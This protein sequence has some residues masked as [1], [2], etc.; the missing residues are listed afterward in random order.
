MIYTNANDLYI[1]MTRRLLEEGIRSSPRGMPVRE[2]LNVQLQITNP[3]WSVVG[4]SGRALNYHFM[5]GESLWMLSGLNR[6]DLI[7][8]FNRNIV[9]ALDDGMHWFQGAY[10][11]KII[12][13]L[14]YVIEVLRQDRA[15]RQA[16][17]TIW[18]ERPR[19]SKDIPC[20]IMMQF[21]IRKDQ[22]HMHTYMRSND[23][24]LGVP[25]DLYNFMLLQQLVAYEMNADLGTY[26]HTVGSIHLYERDEDAARAM[27]KD[28]DAHRVD[29]PMKRVRSAPMAVM[30]AAYAEAALLTKSSN[31]YRWY[32]R[33]TDELADRSK[34]IEPWATMLAVLAHRFNSSIPTAWDSLFKVGR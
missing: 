6:A 17:L 28:P 29:L 26:T 22:L 33:W 10:G 14:G 19:L 13:Q 32:D 8:P 3:L 21:M 27:L 16:V 25:Y 7:K 23:M 9:M 31:V 2:M 1:D 15:S 24:W 18:R 5:V 4:L 11:P 20:T 34:V 12:D 30:T